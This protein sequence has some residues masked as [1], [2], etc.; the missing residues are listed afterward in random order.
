MR[1]CKFSF[2]KWVVE[3]WYFSLVMQLSWLWLLEQVYHQQLF[4]VQDHLNGKQTADLYRLCISQPYHQ[5]YTTEW[6]ATVPPLT[7]TIRRLYTLRRFDMWLWSAI[8]NISLAV[9]EWWSAISSGKRCNKPRGE[10]VFF[11]FFRKKKNFATWIN[12]RS[13][14]KE[15]QEKDKKRKESKV[16]IK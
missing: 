4:S 13:K 7:Q 1:K 14:P 9:I 6:Y 15:E 11:F 5:Q 2:M 16:T 12:Q 10:S 8:S 3:F